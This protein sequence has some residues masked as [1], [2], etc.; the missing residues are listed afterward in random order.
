MGNEVAYQEWLKR[1]KGMLSK[2]LKSSSSKKIPR[3]EASETPSMVI[4]NVEMPKPREKVAVQ[5][6]RPK[7]MICLT[8][9]PL[10][11]RVE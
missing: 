10:K 7:V 9:T 4:E 3:E 5:K 6:K 8:R 2:M 11:T 1:P